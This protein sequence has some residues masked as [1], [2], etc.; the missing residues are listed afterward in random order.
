MYIDMEGVP[1]SSVIISFILVMAI[2]LGLVVIFGKE[3]EQKIE[4]P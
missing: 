1:A 4:S 3:P 2:L